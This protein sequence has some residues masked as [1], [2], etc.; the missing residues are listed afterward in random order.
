MMSEG[1]KY[2]NALTEL[3]LKGDGTHGIGNVL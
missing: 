2:N 1:L 3:N